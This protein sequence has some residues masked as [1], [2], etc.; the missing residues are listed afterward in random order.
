MGILK[1]E[2]GIFEY[3]QKIASA[4]QNIDNLTVNKSSL[5]NFLSAQQSLAITLTLRPCLHKL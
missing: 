1:S 5:A 2:N 4:D 3:F